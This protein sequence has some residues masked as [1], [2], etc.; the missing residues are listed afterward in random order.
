MLAGVITDRIGR[1]GT[2]P[3]P[4]LLHVCSAVAVPFNSARYQ[5]AA[6]WAESRTKRHC[7]ALS[8]SSRTRNSRLLIRGFGVQ[9]PGGAPVP[10]WGFCSPFT[11]VDGRFRAMVAPRLLVSPNIVDHGARTPGEAPTD[12]YTQ[13]DTWRKAQVEGSLQT[14][15][16]KRPGLCAGAMVPGAWRL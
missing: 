16:R 14:Q 15:P 3:L 7:Q 5:A 2:W 9:V 8:G 6:K 13:R 4:C 10:T 11:L 1:L 12:G